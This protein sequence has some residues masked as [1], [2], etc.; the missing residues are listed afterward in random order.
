MHIQKKTMW[1]FH[2][3][4]TLIFDCLA[5]VTTT[6]FVYGIEYGKCQGMGAIIQTAIWF[7]AAATV[8][9][10]PWRCDWVPVGVAPSAGD[11]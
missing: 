10:R 7:Y 6:V 5:P 8:P 11:E 1:C 3:P 4:A 2:P 9:E